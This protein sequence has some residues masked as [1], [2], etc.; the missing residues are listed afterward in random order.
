MTKGITPIF[1]T[2]SKK[3]LMV[4]KATAEEIKKPTRS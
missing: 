1:S 3:Y 2:N 4:K